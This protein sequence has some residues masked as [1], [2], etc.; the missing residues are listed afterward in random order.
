M[1]KRFTETNHNLEYELNNTKRSLIERQEEAR[2][3]IDE[4]TELKSK[5]DD[6]IYRI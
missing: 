6:A 5:L 1:L 2:H 4:N 3:L